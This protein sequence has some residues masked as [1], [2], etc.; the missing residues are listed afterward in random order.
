[1]TTHTLIIAE[2]GVNHDG[3]LETALALVD[4][5]ADA[6]ADIVKF[7][8]FN[9]KALAG[10]AAKKADYQQRTTAADESQL[11]MLERL[12]LPRAAHHTLIERARERGIEFLSTP[13]DDASLAFLLSLKLPRIKIGSGD[14][15]NAPLLH[16]AAKAGA[17]LI[18][19]TGMATLGEIEE[20]LGVLAHGYGPSDAPPGIAAFRAAWRDPAARTALA[21]HVS[22]LHCTTE[23]P[24]PIGDVNL[25][26]MATMRSAFQL[27]VGYSDHTDG[28][29]VSVAA[30]ALGA[31]VIE[32]HLTLDRKAQGPDHAASLEPDDFKRMVMAIRNV[33]RAVGDGVKTPKDSEIRNVPVARKSIV[34]ARALKAGETIGPADI[35]AKRPGAGRPPIDYWSLVGTA[36]PRA[37]E[38]D[39]P[40]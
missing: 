15:T 12:E 33:E 32:K 16:A 18:L 11:A 7:Q 8:T 20:A 26:A 30:V 6:G 19:S 3:S 10:S 38:P 13:F 28:F 17:T 36:A 22:L 40:L 21:Q 23:Y 25:A 35:T 29:E 14:L 9:A 31:T 27:P 34:A 24:C 4:A 2:A 37:L 39:D 1:M 5:A